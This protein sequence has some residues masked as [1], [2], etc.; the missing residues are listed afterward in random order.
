MISNGSRR[1]IIH[2]TVTN[3][4]N[5]PFVCDIHT[6][7]YLQ[8]MIKHTQNESF[9]RKLESCQTQT[10]ICYALFSIVLHKLFAQNFPLVHYTIFI[11][12]WRNKF[13]GQNC[14]SVK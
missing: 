10:K 4:D 14:D 5:Y 9:T 7:H 3:C 1:R 8:T 11:N 13:F 6:T 12:K 2:N